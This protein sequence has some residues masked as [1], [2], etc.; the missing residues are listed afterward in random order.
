ML[1]NSL[2]NKLSDELPL[3]TFAFHL[4]KTM[5]FSTNWFTHVKKEENTLNLERKKKTFPL[6]KKIN[7]LRHLSARV[8]DG[9]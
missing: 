4:K 2:Q 1:V 8:G 7:S 6:L 5:V 3:P 9:W